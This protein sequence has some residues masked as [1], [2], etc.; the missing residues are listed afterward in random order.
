MPTDFLQKETAA[1]RG[2]AEAGEGHLCVAS[3]AATV[4]Q[5]S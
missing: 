2:R 3:L 1:A 5:R 4:D